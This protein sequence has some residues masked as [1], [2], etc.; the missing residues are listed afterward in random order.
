MAA[1]LAVY[2]PVPGFDF[3]NFDDPLWVSENAAIRNGWS[4]D[5][6]VWSFTRATEAA[7]YWVPLTWLSLFFDHAIYGMNPGG[8][9][10][11]NLLFHLANTL[12]VFFCLKRISGAMWPSGFVAALFALHP[13]HV[14]SVAWIT[15]RKDVLSAFFWMLSIWVYA[16]YT[17][18]PGIGRYGLLLF[19]FML[20]IMSKPMLVTLPFVLLV[21]DHWPLNRFSVGR[22]ATGRFFGRPVR[23]KIP[24]F[25]TVVAIA[26][27]TWMTQAQGGAVKPL[28]DIPLDT[29]IANTFVAYVWYLVK[30]VWP[31][32]L[33]AIYPYPHGP[34]MLT[35]TL[36][37]LAL[38]GITALAAWCRRTLPF[39]AVGWLWYLITLAPVCGLVVIGPHAVADR[40]T[41]IPLTGIF[42]I[43]AWG[44]QALAKTLGMKKNAALAIALLLVIA[45]AA[46]T[47][48]Q[49]K[50]WQN[51]T[52][53][54]Q[55]ALDVTSK[56]YLAHNNLGQAL[57]ETGRFPEAIAQFNAA[58]AL[59]PDS[60]MAYHGRA[61]VLLAVGKVDAALDDYNRAIRLDPD[62][63]DAY[64]GAGNAYFAKGM[65]VTAVARY[66]SAIA[67][68]ADFAEAHNNLGLALIELKQ[69]ED[70]LESFRKAIDILSDFD[71]ARN[72]LGNALVTLGRFDEAMAQFLAVLGTNPASKETHYHLGLAMEKMGRTQAA[73]H[74]YMRVLQ[75]DPGFS[76][77]HNNL[78]VAMI[79]TGQTAKAAA[80]FKAVL[81]LQ[82][83]DTM[84][85]QNLDLLRRMTLGENTRNKAFIPESRTASGVR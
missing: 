21:M 16:W 82:P 40:Y 25:F 45:C 54:F 15:E 31:V 76:P 60:A 49:I 73:I 36:C 66:R 2:H 58:Q 48:G 5:A 11:T 59:N 12:L 71:A 32:N 79:K 20:G 23:E 83:H 14:E 17:E 28:A 70:G 62:F 77:A 33:A 38:A 61:D 29:R 63:E 46:A 24:L 19:V 53:L 26:I 39:V 68:R 84:A 69:W 80:H 30:M 43:I 42:I 4:W 78:G 27:I 10:F 72:N 65:I 75:L 8:Y 22:P 50:Y 81:R 64:N 57:I 13:L 1:T 51:S 37:G 74:H 67:L 85:K 44:A 55:R 6:L 35:A 41:Y 34:S 18:K 9:H 7:N 56:N 47:Q 3:V 52:T